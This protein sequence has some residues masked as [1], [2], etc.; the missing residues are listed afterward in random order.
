MKEAEVG[1]GWRPDDFVS[2][3]LCLCSMSLV[4]W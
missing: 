3:G 1:E 2:C 4:K